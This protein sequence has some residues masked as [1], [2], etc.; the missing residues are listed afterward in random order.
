MYMIQP[1]ELHDPSHPHYHYK[2]DKTFYGLKQAPHDWYSRLSLSVPWDKG[3]I[4]TKPKE[5]CPDPPRVGS[6]V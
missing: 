6:R 3:T 4:G 5:H 1:P 2:L